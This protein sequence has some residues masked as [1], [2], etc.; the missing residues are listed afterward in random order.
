MCSRIHRPRD[1]IRDYGALL[2]ESTNILDAADCKIADSQ[3]PI[4]NL[5]RPFAIIADGDIAEG[6]SKLAI[7]CCELLN[8]ANIESSIF[9]P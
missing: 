7:G 4:A 9:T 8:D 1:L 3:Q 5:E 6:C 2:T